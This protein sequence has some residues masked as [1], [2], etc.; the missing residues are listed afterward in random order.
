VSHKFTDQGF[1]QGKISFVADFYHLAKTGAR[2]HRRVTDESVACERVRAGAEA[3]FTFFIVPDRC[4]GVT[5]PLNG[6]RT[7][8]EARALKLMMCAW[9][10]YLSLVGAIGVSSSV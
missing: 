8:F 7:D 2:S 5:I 10:H 6:D 9:L 3:M 1:I 4:C